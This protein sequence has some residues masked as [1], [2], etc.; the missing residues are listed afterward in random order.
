MNKNNHKT[1]KT[2][3]EFELKFNDFYRLE[4]FIANDVYSTVDG[5]TPIVLQ[6]F[7]VK[8]KK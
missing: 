5:D 1:P 3:S 2:W 8:K 6:N 4:C 7:N